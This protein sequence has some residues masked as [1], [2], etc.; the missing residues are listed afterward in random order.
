MTR[1]IRIAL[2]TVCI[3]ASSPALSQ[4]QAPDPAVM[5]RVAAA[6]Q[7]Q[8]NQVMDSLAVAEAKNALLTDELA[9]ANVRIKELETKPDLKK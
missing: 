9:K 4:Q 5:Q 3:L 1:M 7:S 6:L 8:R 2:T